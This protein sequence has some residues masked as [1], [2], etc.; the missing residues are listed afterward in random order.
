MLFLIS[1]FN[2]DHCGCP[3]VSIDITSLQ[4]TLSKINGVEYAF[5]ANNIIGMCGIFTCVPKESPG[6]EY[7]QTIDFGQL[8]TIKRTW[9]RFPKKSTGVISHHKSKEDGDDSTL[10][11]SRMLSIDAPSSMKTK[12]CVYSF[13]EI[14]SFAD[15]HAIIHS[16]AREYMGSDYDLLRK[17]CCTF[18]LDACIRL[19]VEKSDIP[20]W[21]YNAAQAGADAED[22]I[23]NMEKSV[24]G[25]LDCHGGVDPLDLE[26]YNHGF[27]VIMEEEKTHNCDLILTVMESP[28][29]R[30]PRVRRPLNDFNET[31]SWTY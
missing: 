16:M 26:C 25:M 8:H 2:E 15:G 13:C 11:D 6:Y 27:E 23:S 1:S 30:T 29:M 5:G 20:K 28:A 24:W 19:G 7:R 17:N 21:F 10:D 31:A 4:S 14:E 9:I 3:H 18:A 12:K 22:A